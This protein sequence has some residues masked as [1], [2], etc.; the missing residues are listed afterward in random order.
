MINFLK[1]KPIIIGLIALAVVALVVPVAIVSAA[2]ANS[3][4]RPGS[5]VTVV[6]G[7][8]SSITSTGIVITTTASDG[9]TSEVSLAIDSNTD[10]NIHGV[11]WLS[12]SLNGKTVIAS[13]K[14]N[15]TVTLPVA[16]QITIN[17]PKP[18]VPATSITRMGMMVQGTIASI[19]G[20]TLTITLTGTNSGNL[21]ANQKV[22]IMAIPVQGATGKKITGEQGTV[23]SI[24]GNTLTITLSGTG[25]TTLTI[26][27]MVNIGP[28]MGMGIKRPQSIPGGMMRGFPQSRF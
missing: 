18:T 25:S 3:S 6:Q 4:S 22:F 21:A 27:Q 14:N 19:T 2:P 7:V 24:S 5:N 13:Y 9:T 15:Q 20:N 26:G 28:G 16:G 8:I 17:M 1:R 11:D 12:S 23:T 10:F